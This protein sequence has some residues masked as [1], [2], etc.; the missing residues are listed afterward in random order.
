MRL[1]TDRIRESMI[2]NSGLCKWTG[3]HCRAVFYLDED[4]ETKEVSFFSTNEKEIEDWMNG[5]IG[6]L[7]ANGYIYQTVTI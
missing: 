6:K 2:E 3:L 7:K 1:N 4:G 5:M